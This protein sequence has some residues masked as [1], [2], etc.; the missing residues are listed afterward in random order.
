MSTVNLNIDDPPTP[1]P[2]ISYPLPSPLLGLMMSP[3]GLPCFASL[4]TH[5]KTPGDMTNPSI[6]EVGRRPWKGFLILSISSPRVLLPGLEVRSRSGGLRKILEGVRSRSHTH[7]TVLHLTPNFSQVYF[8]HL[9][10]SSEF[11]SESPGH[12]IPVTWDFGPRVFLFVPLL[13][14]L[15]KGNFVYY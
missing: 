1:K 10:V 15:L 8:T 7:L 4:L 5:G 11:W 12:L 13:F 14:C 6:S 9:R 2:L 3:G